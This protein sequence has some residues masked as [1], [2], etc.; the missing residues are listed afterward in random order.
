VG[1]GNESRVVVYS[2]SNVMWAT[3]LWW[4]LR[5]AGHERV[6]VLDGGF[7]KWRSDGHPNSADPCRYTPSTFV[8]EMRE[9]HWA[10]KQDVQLAVGDEKTLIDAV[11][12]PIR[13]DT[14]TFVDEVSDR[15]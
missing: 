1:I 7:A 9:S 3:R 6:A 15:R 12:R 5:S 8:A 14:N 2:S 4:L 11:D 13:R 10:T